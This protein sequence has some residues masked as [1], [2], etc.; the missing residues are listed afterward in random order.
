MWSASRPTT[1][2]AAYGGAE[3]EA[4]EEVPP[5]SVLVPGAGRAAQ[6]G[7]AVSPGDDGHGSEIGE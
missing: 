1:G 2:Q 4:G 5:V 6:L 7:L 3:L